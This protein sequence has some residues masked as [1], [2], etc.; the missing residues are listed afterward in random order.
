MTDDYKPNDTINVIDW[1]GAKRMPLDEFMSGWL[2]LK[3]RHPVRRLQP[4]P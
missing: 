3:T 1:T 4:T 2:S